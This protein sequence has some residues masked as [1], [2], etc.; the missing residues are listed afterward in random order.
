MYP[1]CIMITLLPVV[2]LVAHGMEQYCQVGIIHG[3]S[4]ESTLR[5]V[6]CVSEELL[7]EDMQGLI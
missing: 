7:T 3:P 2:R 5:S 6:Q 4:H 1:S